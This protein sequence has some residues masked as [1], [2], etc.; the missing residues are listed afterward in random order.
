MEILSVTQRP[1]LALSQVERSGKNADSTGEQ[2]GWGSSCLLQ[3]PKGCKEPPGS[4]AKADSEVPA[5][6]GEGDRQPVSLLQVA[7][8]DEHAGSLLNVIIVLD[9]GGPTQHAIHSFILQTILKDLLKET[10]C[11]ALRIQR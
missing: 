1:P 4:C 10:L 8:L 2:A 3:P 9:T 5:S 11:W 6:L 7:S